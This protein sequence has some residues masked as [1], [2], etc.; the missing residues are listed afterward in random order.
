MATAATAWADPYHYRNVIIGDRSAGLAGAYT[1]IADDAPGLY[2]NPAGVVYSSQPKISGSVNAYN[3]KVTK[4]SDINNSGHTWERISK[5]MVANYFGIVQPLDNK[6]SVGFSIAIPNHELE[7]QSDA[8]SNFGGSSGTFLTQGTTNYS[9][10][11]VNSQQI[12]YNNE[13]TTTLVGASYSKVLTD[14]LSIGVTLYAYMR[15]QELTNWQYTR[16]TLKDNSN[17]NKIY[18]DIL[19]QKIQTEEFGL[20]PR[21]GLM[22]SPVPKWS[23]GLMMQ[24]TAILSQSPEQRYQ[25]TQHLCDANGQNCDLLNVNNSGTIL[26]N[27]ISNIPSL[28]AT[29]DNDLPFET[30]LGIAYFQS[31]TTLYSF[32]FSYADATSIYQA[33]WNAAAAMEYF[34]NSSWA[35]RGGLYTNNANTSDTK[36]AGMDDHVDIIGGAFSISRYTKTSNITLGINL[37]QGSGYGDLNDNTSKVQKIDI[38][39]VNLFISTSASF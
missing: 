9:V 33:T 10:S 27:N 14:T 11:K 7:D 6:S 12:D 20:Q 24:K 38:S 29:Q 1:A 36:K 32:D 5:G 8:F 35:L 30:T 19:Y 28:K 15:K 23:V 18:E 31:N 13:D 2:Y 39:G 21:L 37:Y 26:N 22:W 25:Y 34:L 16:A 4:Y 3:Y 17:N